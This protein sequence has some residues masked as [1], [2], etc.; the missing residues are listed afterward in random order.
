VCV[1][2]CMKRA[3]FVTCGGVLCTVVQVQVQVQ[4]LSTGRVS[5][6][7]YSFLMFFLSFFFYTSVETQ[8]YKSVSSLSQ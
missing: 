6:N 8:L 2:V 4:V 3:V 1:Y 5:F 7:L